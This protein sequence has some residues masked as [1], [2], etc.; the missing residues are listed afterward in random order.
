MSHLKEAGLMSELEGGATAVVDAP[1]VEAPTGPA[2]LGEAMSLGLEQRFNSVDSFGHTVKPEAD[3]TAEAPV[4]EPVVEA[5]QPVAEVAPEP[6]L[7]PT[8]DPV[9]EE[10]RALRAELAEVKQ[11][12]QPDPSQPSAL[13][14][15][16]ES[17]RPELGND[18]VLAERLAPYWESAVNKVSQLQARY[19]N[20]TEEEVE[21]IQA[22]AGIIR[23]AFDIEMRR[24]S[25]IRDVEVR[26]EQ[27]EIQ[28]FQQEAQQAR[29][30]WV[31]ETQKLL[32]P[33]EL[34]LVNT[35]DVTTLESL[36]QAI[37]VGHASKLNPADVVEL[38]RQIRQFVATKT[39]KVPAATTPVVQQVVQQVVV[40]QARQPRT[41]PISATGVVTQAEGSTEAGASDL[42]QRVFG[43]KK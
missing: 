8:P 14:S 25:M 2:N 22:E 5:E 24:Q 39:G 33:D 1:A 13:E 26:Q 9:L 15:F 35:G 41:L 28:K 21:M 31:S 34:A 42:Y 40:P 11:G 7:A 29:T 27:A 19:P 32:T 4:E 20:P 43:K 3:A 37:N 17:M 30:Y 36:K 12:K 6:A 38:S 16:P 10:L 18:E 23:N